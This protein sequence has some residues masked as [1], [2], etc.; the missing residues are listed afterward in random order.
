MPVPLLL[1]IRVVR[2]FCVLLVVL[3]VPSPA[4]STDSLPRSASRRL[5]FTATE[6]T[7][8]EPGKLADL[9]ILDRNPLYDIANTLSISQVMINGRLLQAA[10]LNN[11]WPRQRALPR[12]IGGGNDRQVS[13]T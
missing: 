2:M 1:S 12:V 3:A 11:V 7:C 8:I 6:G 13:T 9:Q 5:Q 4:Q 10:T